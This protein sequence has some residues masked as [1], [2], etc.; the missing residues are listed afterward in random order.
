MLPT[1]IE[2]LE[3]AV[4]VGLFQATTPVFVTDVPSTKLGLRVARK[5][6]TTTPPG[7]SAPLTEA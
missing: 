5:R 4:C 1:T 2:T 6:S 7:A 3:L